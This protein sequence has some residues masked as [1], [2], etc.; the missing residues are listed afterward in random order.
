[1]APKE[2][3]ASSNPHPS[4]FPS[5]LAHKSFGAN[6]RHK[7][8]AIVD[9]QC[10]H[11]PFTIRTTRHSLSIMISVATCAKLSSLEL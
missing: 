2:I 4:N 7:Q 9:Q 5:L 8:V 6:P 11:L 3:E 10:M 1:M